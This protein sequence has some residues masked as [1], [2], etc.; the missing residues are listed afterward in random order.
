MR[1]RSLHQKWHSA[2]SISALI[3]LAVLLALPSLAILRLAKSF[4]PRFLLGYVV[5]ISVITFWLNWHDKKRAGSGRRRVPEFNLHLAE[6]LGGWPGALLA[7][8]I[9][10]HKTAKTRYQVVFWILVGLH[11]V[12]SLGF[13]S[14]WSYS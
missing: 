10:R 8:R 5:A 6:L 11:E 3:L 1:N 14:G 2:P 12:A 4:D 9:V 7:Q 13:L